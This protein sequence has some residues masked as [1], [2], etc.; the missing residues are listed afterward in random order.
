MA[1][2]K[3]KQIEQLKLKQAKKAFTRAKALRALMNGADPNEARFVK[4]ANFHV[5][6]KSWKLL[7]SVMPS[8]PAEAQK[9]MLDLH[10]KPKLPA[11][12]PFC[13]LENGDTRTTEEQIANV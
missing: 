2:S 9:L 12:V 13:S 1:V 4:H 3:V 10:I 11:E 7:G 6:N 5:R 8:D